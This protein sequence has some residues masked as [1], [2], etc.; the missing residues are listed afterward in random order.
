MKSS[1]HCKARPS[2]TQL[3]RYREALGKLPPQPQPLWLWSCW[4]AGTSIKETE[5]GTQQLLS[6]C[7]QT[8]GKEQ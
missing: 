6:Q 1:A 3:G 7:S 4:A 8:L 2:K 5:I